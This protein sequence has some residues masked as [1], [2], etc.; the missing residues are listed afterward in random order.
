MKL[1]VISIK[2]E[3]EGEWMRTKAAQRHFPK[4][5]VDEEQRVV[6]PKTNKQTSKQKMQSKHTVPIC[7]LHITLYLRQHLG[8]T[9][10]GLRNKSNCLNKAD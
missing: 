8:R 9:Q 6:H 1:S 3:D 7:L 10:F 2:I 5:Q 4:V